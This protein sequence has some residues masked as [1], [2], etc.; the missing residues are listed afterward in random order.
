MATPGARCRTPASCTRL[1]RDTLS[2]ECEVITDHLSLWAQPFGP[3]EDLP[4]R[5]KNIL[6][7]Y[8]ASAPDLVKEV[9]QNA[10][11]A[12]AGLLHFVWDRRQHP[13]KATF[14][15]EWKILQGPALCIYN[16]RPFQQRDIEGI[17]HLGVGSKQGRQDVTGK[18]GLGFNTVY[19]FTDCPA[20]LTGDSTLCVSDPHLYY[21]PTATTEKPGSMFTVNTDFKKNFPDI[22]DTFLPSF[23]DLKQGVLFRLPLRTA[24][25]AAKSRV[26][27][28]VVRDQDLK[29]M[30]ET[31]AK[32]GEDLVL[33]L[34][35]V[36]T[37]IFSEIP[38]DG[39]EL[40]EKLRVT[41]EL[42]EEDAKL[43]QDFQARLSQATD[44]NSPTPLS[45]TMKVKNSRAKTTSLWRVISQIG[46]Q[47]GAEES[48]ELKWLPYG[49]VAA[50]MEP[51]K[52][53][54][55]R[56][57]CTLPLPLVTGLPLHIN[58]NFSVDAARCRLHWDKGGTGATWNGFLLRRLVVPLYCYFLTGK[59]WSQKSSSISPWNSARS[60]WTPTSSTFPH[61]QQICEEFIEAQVN[62]VVLGPDSLQR[63]LKALA[64]P[65]PCKLAETPLRNPESCSYL[66]RYL[67]GR[68]R[69][70][71]GTHK[72]GD[73]AILEGLPLLA[74]EDGLLN[75]FSSQHP[76]FKNSFAK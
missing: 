60:T 15:E 37:I 33:F 18:Y 5:L 67:T 38:P 69:H 21:V 53:V 17:Q 25:E 65:V 72:D 28:M 51:L 34:R 45:Y 44:G 35:H 52:R 63:F 27:D 20:F 31:L 16:D 59:P 50:R 10:D 73:K 9:L 3:H 56:A 39:K 54:M 66:L 12:G 24:A 42:T 46:V 62:T 55:G 11:D 13:V 30:E 6:K 19:H 49:A 68:N 71:Q 32:E 75:A 70:S 47:D 2:W 4:T 61:L 40:V 29:N 43:R 48:P 41:T 8:S 7:E 26:S 22:Y 58:A 74:T 57:F 1:W 76:V 64:L 14:S 23:F 36:H